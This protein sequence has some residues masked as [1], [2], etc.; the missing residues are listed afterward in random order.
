MLTPEELK[1]IRRLTLQTGRRVDSLFAGGYRSA[2]KGRGM[3]FEEVRPYVHG[4]DVRHIDWNVTARTLVTHVKEYRE[5]RE[6][7]LVLGIDVSGSMDFGSGG[8]DGDTDK[9]RQL[10]RVGGALAYA[11]TR[12]N[13]RVGLLVFSD[14]IERFVPPRKSRGHA[15]RVIREVYGHQAR[16]QKTDLAGAMDYLGRVVRRRA[17]VCLISDFIAPSGWIR[18]LGGLAARHQVHAFVVHDPQE[19]RTGP[20]AMPKGWLLGAVDAETGARRWLDS[21][22]LRARRDLDEAL[23]AI[24]RTGAH[25]TPIST[26]EDPF[27]ALEIHF[28]RVGARR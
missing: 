7:T 23:R 10:A 1:Q 12:N 22:R 18:S 3:E 11:A 27:R 25:A 21:S 17:V 16:G 5:E 15:W 24:A 14:H 19:G 8:L 28:K 2:F 26:R 9:R 6:L 4:D 13:D 20:A